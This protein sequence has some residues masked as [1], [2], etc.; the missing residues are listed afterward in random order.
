M[1]EDRAIG[2]QAVEVRGLDRLVAVAAGIASLVVDHEHDN[3]APGG[4][5]GIGGPDQQDE[6]A[7]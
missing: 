4:L 7:G 6:Q 5:Q 1:L 3:V 2:C